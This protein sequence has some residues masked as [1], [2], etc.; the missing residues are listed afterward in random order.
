MWFRQTG[1][2]VDDVL[3][4][5]NGV[6]TR[7]WRNGALDT[8]DFPLDHVSE[9]LAEDAA[10]VWADLC[11]PDHEQLQ[12]LAEE[13]GLDVHAVE[14][15]VSFGERPKATR[16]ANHTFVMTYAARL[17]QAEDSTAELFQSRLQLTRISAFVLPRGLV[18][19]RSDDG[20]EM[21]AVIER[22]EE[23]ADL[24]ALGPGALLHGLLDVVVDGHFEAVQQLDDAIEDLEGA[25]FDGDIPTRETQQLTFRMRK[26]LVQL[27]RVVLPM[28]EV[29]NTIMRH[30]SEL[31]HEGNAMDGWFADLYDHVLRAAEWT[32]SLRDMVTTIFETTLSLQDAR[33]NTIMKKLTA[34]A[35]II[36]VPTAVTG[37]FGQ[38]IP[39]PGFQEPLG[40]WLATGTISILA[41]GLYLLFRRLDWI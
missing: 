6:T 5:A 20:F 1:T 39:Y 8:K 36:A 32:E 21:G 10:L 3:V 29:V 31:G 41:L 40:L 7:L 35:A 34:W 23:N 2:G 12:E 15:A 22:W 33:L 24:L 4:S 19:V 11:G 26:E 25:L 18:T 13:L 37:W 14:D 9:H 27:R 17:E 38:N 30:R 16:H 28:R